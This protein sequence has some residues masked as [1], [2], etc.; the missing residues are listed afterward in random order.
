MALGGLGRRRKKHECKAISGQRLEDLGPS[1]GC[2]LEGPSSF[3]D[4][5]LWGLRA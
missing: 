4:L 5:G 3:W 1:S 2:R